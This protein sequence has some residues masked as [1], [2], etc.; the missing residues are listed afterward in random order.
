MFETFLVSGGIRQ[1]MIVIHI[2]H[3]TLSLLEWAIPASKQELED[4]A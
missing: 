4:Q 2:E 1:Q 3:S